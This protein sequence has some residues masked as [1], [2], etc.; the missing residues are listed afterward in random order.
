MSN[1]HKFAED[2]T[3]FGLFIIGIILV[4]IFMTSCSQTQHGFDYKSHGKSNAQWKHKAEHN[5]LPKCN[6]H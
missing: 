4:V 2:I 6:R 5:K 1:K 3:A